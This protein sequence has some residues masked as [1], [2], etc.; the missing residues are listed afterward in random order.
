MTAY[1]ALG[2][3]LFTGN[4]GG[5]AGVGTTM[6]GS[7]LGAR[8]FTNPR[9]VRWLAQQTEKPVSALPASINQL[10]QIAK[11]DPEAAELLDQIQAQQQGQSRL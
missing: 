7:N 10:A 2:G 11:D 8:A 3:L 5:A 9:F 4:F 1:S 6:V